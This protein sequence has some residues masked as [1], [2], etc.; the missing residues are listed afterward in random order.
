[1]N[2]RFEKFKN[3]T[4]KARKIVEEK[5]DLKKDIERV[6]VEAIEAKSAKMICLVAYNFAEELDEKIICKMAETLIEIGEAENIYSFATQV[7]NAPIKK[8]AEGIIATK[9]A[10][11]IEMFARIKGAPIDILAD[12]IIELRNAQAIYSFALNVKGAPK[13]KMAKAILKVGKEEDW[14]AYALDIMHTS[15]VDLIID[16]AE[17]KRDKEQ[18][19]ME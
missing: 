8:L 12:A 9:D 1:M 15:V 13:K 4:N 19:E 7:K 17:I 18:I 2:N 16:Y 6:A 14:E 5:K 11:Y 3:I 10:D